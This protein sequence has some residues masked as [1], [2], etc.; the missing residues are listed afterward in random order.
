M[1]K[2][3]IIFGK[4]IDFLEA[5]ISKLSKKV[6]TSQKLLIRLLVEHFNDSLETVDG[7]IIASP[8]NYRLV[9]ELDSIFDNY[10]NISGKE[11]VKK[12]AI[13]L[14][15]VRSYNVDYFTELGFESSKVE[16]V[17]KSNVKIRKSLGLTPTGRL[18][19]GSLLYDISTLPSVRNE[20]RD[21]VTSAL[22]SEDRSLKSLRDGI[23]QRIDAPPRV[24]GEKAKRG[25]LERYY[26]RYAF[27]KFREIDEIT[28]DS[29][30][31]ALG[32]EHFIYTG[33]LI[34]TSRK[35]CIKRNARAFTV[36]E[37]KVWKDDPDLIDKKTKKSYQPLI[38]LGRNGCRHS[39]RYITL[40]LYNKFKL[41]GVA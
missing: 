37:T 8:N 15:A 3:E 36:E 34:T 41:K 33:G 5:S 16:R 40:R 28:N 23:K 18:K 9:A 21:F 17:I 1:T 20:L 6:R 31:K 29:A 26:H 39:K 10:Y 4:K 32:L 13:D 38:E 19:K 22:L 2:A 35:F 14:L 11:L 24:E 25:R 7:V 27:D 12:L 30:A